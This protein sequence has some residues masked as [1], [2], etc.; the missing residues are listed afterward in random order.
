MPESNQQFHHRSIE[1]RDGFWKEQAA[2]IEWHKPFN[3]V[4]DYSRPPFAKWF[5]GGETNLCHNA[6]DRHLAQRGN[7]P[8]LVFISSETGQERSYSYAELHA[9]VNTFAAMLLDLGAR[10]GDRIII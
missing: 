4:L 9:E 1:D 3:Q 2:L 7:Q 5:C 6:L 10:R 8:A